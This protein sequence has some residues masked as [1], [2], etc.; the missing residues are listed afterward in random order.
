ML[1]RTAVV[2][3]LILAAGLVQAA[4]ADE[5]TLLYHES[6]DNGKIEGVVGKAGGRLRIDARD[7]ID[8]DRGTLALFVQ[9]K[10]AP[11]ISEWSR[12]VG[13]N[14]IRGGGYWGMLMGF[15]MRRQDFLFTFYDV[16]RYAPPLHLPPNIERWKAGEWHHLAAVWDRDEG[17]TAYED[18]K[19]VAS[20]RGKHRWEWNLLPDRLN[21]YS[22][23]DEVFIFAEPLTDGQIAQ[24]AQGQ[25]PTGA[26][27][28]ITPA[29]ARRPRDLARMGWS[30]ESVRHIP[31]LEPGKPLAL[32]FARIVR[33]VDAKRP[34]AQPHEGFAVTTWPLIKYGASIRGERLDIQLAPGSSYDRVRVFLH[35][36]FRGA[37]VRAAT[38]KDETLAAIDEPRA[39]IWHR[40]LGRMLTDEQVAL[41]RK[42]GRLGQIDFYRVDPLKAPDVPK[43]V[44]A[45]T[46]AGADSLPADET[47]K[48]LTAETP[49]RFRS[50]ALGTRKP[51]PAWTL[52]APAFG[53]FQAVTEALPEARAFDGALVTLVAEGITRPT[54]VRVQIKEP[55]HGMRDWL[56]G[57]VVLQPRGL[58]KQVYTLC[59][60]G[61][62]VINMPPMQK[63]KYWKNGKY[64]DELLPVPGI[65]FGVKVVAANP[66]TWFMGKDGCAVAFCTTDMK[67]ALPV[68]AD[69]QT[70]YMREGYAEVMEGHA[71]RDRRIVIPLTWLAKFAP[72]RMKTRQ[73]YERV[74]SPKYFH[75]MS[76]PKLVY[77]PPKN[78]TGAPDWAFW[79][80]QAMK[81][82]RRLIHWR[83]DNQQVRTGEF[84]G[85]WNDDTI[86]TENWYGFA[87]CMDD[88]GKI[89]NALRKFL[90]GNWKHLHN[91][92]G[93]YTQDT[94]H[95]YEEGMGSQ[96]MRMLID[97][98][99]PVAMTRLMTSCSHYDKWLMP[100][101]KGG[102]LFRSVFVSVD[103]AWTC[104]AFGKPFKARGHAN[105]I[106]VPAGYLIWYNRHPAV[107]RYYRGLTPG[108]YF[109]GI[110]RDQ[111]TDLDAA[112]TRY[113]EELLKKMGRR[114]R[115]KSYL[116]YVDEVGLS[117]EARKVHYVKYA[118]PRPIPHYWGAHDT[119][120]HW[121]NF[122]ISGDVR[123]LVGSYQRVCEWFYSHDWLNTG[124]MAS[125][126]RNPL[127]RYSL[128]RARMGSIAANRGSSGL[129][130][131]V[132]GLTYV[133]GA[134]D[135]AAIVTE[136]LPTTL[137]V[138]FY[139]FTDKPHAMQIR[140]WRLNGTFKVTLSHDKND[141]GKPEG[142]ISS[143]EMALDRGAFIDLTLPPKQAS[144]LTITPVRPV[145]MVYDLPDPAVGPRTVGLGRDGHLVARVYNLGVRPVRN[146]I[147]R[148]SDAK[149][150]RV[151]ETRTIRQIDAP[152]DLKPRYVDV[153]FPS[154]TAGMRNRVVVE[155]D[156]GGKA[157]DLNRYNNAIA[158]VP[159]GSRLE[160]IPVRRVPKAT[161]KKPDPAL[162][163]GSV[164]LVYGEHLVVRV[165]NIGA[166]PVKDCVVRVRDGRSGEL[167]V[168]GEKRTGP[169][170]APINQ[171]P[172][173]R[174]VEFKN[175]NCSIY[176]SLIVEVDPDRELDDADR[177]NNRFVLIY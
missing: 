164:D 69:D 149:G 100:D 82:H 24:L 99:D 139:P 54:P 117:D 144:I 138:R 175:I 158:L 15:D 10:T 101:G 125:M 98:G 148:V 165:Y 1:R 124:A 170:G 79:Q 51:A 116:L 44:V 13:L 60:K 50:P 123:W 137:S 90:D 102:Y 30:G 75:G 3:V 120:R 48:T 103:G 84:G 16:G 118:Q 130:W 12:P 150:G 73:M 162:L 31:S 65:G 87:L 122:K 176:G 142:A 7:I 166:R 6:F 160:P 20:N 94:C 9:S 109:H 145:P 76:V 42:Q 168:M 43:Q 161:H 89:K 5:L 62:P 172:Q 146:V 156:P 46:F 154:V 36:K 78:D 128:I 104:G 67:A 59:L 163:E 115:P 11:V 8:L 114:G 119:D 140:T 151:I 167:V 108:G 70:E 106:L 113:A 96:A 147:V 56:I 153:P 18:G 112:R 127:P 21:I 97:Y 14:G 4:R 23:V 136:N 41:T 64:H 27:I 105:D 57:D 159:H 26:P 45:F 40:P 171:E 155:I 29:A 174:G 55:V 37:F 58:G 47:G 91:G 141:D 133:K 93:K 126:D 72:E 38:G 49:V 2:F 28:P 110:A 129:V 35:R 111:V 77:E 61:R 19:R 81:E 22:P 152:L 32:T 132:Y 52:A 74:G 33:C 121:F 53:G 68:C 92:V 95:F 17:V 135:M 25:K 131:P 34:V 143:K 63:Q 80:M 107:A 83:I 177:N 134:N 66:V 157:P 86:H 88:A 169:I 173:D 39:T 85:I 71:Y